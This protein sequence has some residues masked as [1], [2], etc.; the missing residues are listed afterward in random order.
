MED[1]KQFGR[2]S[3]WSWR[4]GPQIR[5]ELIVR[6]WIWRRFHRPLGNW[7]Y[8]ISRLVQRYL[9]YNRG[10]CA[11][12][13]FLIFLRLKKKDG[14]LKIPICR[15][16]ANAI[17]AINLHYWNSCVIARKQAIAVKF[18]KIRIRRTIYNANVM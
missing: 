8:V 11:G 6:S 3:K 2:F 7:N 5:L 16:K 15:K 1:H 9:I 12:G 17:I 18:A 13:L 14:Y 10:I 4:D